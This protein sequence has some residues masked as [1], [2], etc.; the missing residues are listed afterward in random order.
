VVDIFRIETEQTYLTWSSPRRSDSDVDSIQLAGR[1]AISPSNNVNLNIKVWRQ[2]LPSEA[3]NNVEVKVGPCLYEETFYSLLIRSTQK[4]QV[5]LKHRDATIL[6]GL[7]SSTDGSIIHGAI[8]FKSQIGRSRFSVYVDGKPEYDFEVEVF[9]SKLDY[10]VDYNVLLAEVQDLLT[11]LALEYL[12]STFK[13]GFASDSP[14][15]SRLEWILLLRHVLDD[16]ERGLHYIERHPHH[17]LVRERVPTRIERLRRSDATISKMVAQG[18]GQGPKSKTISGLLLHTK[19]PERRTRV[20]WDTPEH[21]W[22]ASQLT[23][24]RRSLAE[25]HLAE[26]SSYG[27]NPGLRQRRTLE[28]IENL[29]NRIAVLQS[30]EPIAQARGFAPAAFTSLTLQARPGYREAYL[31]CLILHLGLRVEGGPVG[32]SVKDIH[33]LYEYWCYLTLVRLI[34]KV[35]GEPVSAQELFSIEQNGLR[36]RLKQGKRQTIKFFNGQRTIELT[37][38]PQY[39]GEAFI[40]PQKPDLVL[41]FRDPHWPTMQLVFDVKYR[42]NTE[43]SYVKQFG[44]PGPPQAAIDALHRYRDAILEETGLHGS[45]SERFKR[46]VVEGVALFPYADVDNQF[47][48]SGFWSALER[49]GIG[50]IPFLPRETR[51]VEEWLRAILQRGGWPTAERVI[52]YLSFEQ[53][54]AWQEA[55]KEAVLVGVLRQNAEE[56]LAWIK[57]KR[58]YYTAFRSETGRQLV[59]RWVGIYS[60]ASIRTPGAITHLAAVEKIDIKKRH[61]IDTPWEPLHEADED[62]VVYQLGEVRELQRPI[63]NRGQRFSGNRWTSRLGM[64]RATELRELF[65]ETSMEWRLYEQLRV[66]GIAFTLEPGAAKLQDQNDP[67]GRTWFVKKHLRVQ[68]QGAAGFFIRRTG[69]PNFFQS[70]LSEVV[71]LFISPA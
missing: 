38:N 32:V 12:R 68:Y 71:K 22:L 57:L 16:L 41:T 64:L 13:L 35:T 26:R 63:E 28:E 37:Y 46:T 33:Q 19:L 49:L 59:S 67:R 5:E 51:Y 14:G 27:K 1:L 21:R 42:V 3:A 58:C 2:G 23:G 36:V 4:Q 39:T 11:S 20:T 47:Q 69:R 24:I 45:R 6:Q 56:H 50:A 48:K 18:K 52:P 44:S 15:S 7:H 34:A 53:L 65:L 54:R 61:E 43:P 29:E 70:D 66:A 60:P 8:N 62:Q 17:G 55:E 31:S 40:L 9:P 30:L 25:I 10:V